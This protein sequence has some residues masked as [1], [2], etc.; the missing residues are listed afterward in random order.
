MGRRQGPGGHGHLGDDPVQRRHKPENC[1]LA[2]LYFAAGCSLLLFA[3]TRISCRDQSTARS[4]GS[5]KEEMIRDTAYRLWKN[6][7]P[8][9]VVA[10]KGRIFFLD[11]AMPFDQLF[12]L[13]N[14]E[15]GYIIPKAEWDQQQPW[16]QN[17]S[18]SWYGEVNSVGPDAAPR[19]AEA[20]RSL[21]R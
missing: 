3:S 1:R 2:L 18:K 16:L 12:G 20:L 4:Q 11:N 17:A 9:P 8:S 7:T 15:V 5:Q 19:I 10:G 14:D 13:A 21:I 6:R